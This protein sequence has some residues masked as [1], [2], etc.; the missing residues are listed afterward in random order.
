MN[1]YITDFIKWTINVDPIGGNGGDH[2]TF[3][4]R[5][6]PLGRFYP[7]A[8]VGIDCATDYVIN[9]ATDTL[10]TRISMSPQWVACIYTVISNDKFSID[11]L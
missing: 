5:A 4:P 1:H 3:P 8:I 6:R 9:E 11:P 7:Q 2:A 10:L